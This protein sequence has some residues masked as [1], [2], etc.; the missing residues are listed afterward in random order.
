MTADERAWL[1]RVRVARRRLRA[2]CGRAMRRLTAAARADLERSLYGRLTALAARVPA[3]DGGLDA[4]LAEHPVLA[5]LV[6]SAVMQWVEAT[7]EL[8]TRWDADR[9]LV[10]ALHEGRALGRVCGVRCDLSDPHG[11]GR[12]VAVVRT[13]R[14]ATVVY[15]PRPLRVD[16]AFEG[17]VR[18]LADAAPTLPPLR[19]VHTIDRGAY[20]WAEYVQ[21]APCADDAARERYHERVGALLCLA[22]LLRGADLHGENVIAAGEQPLLVDLEALP[23][24]V[25]PAFRV[26]RGE[27]DASSVLHTGLLPAVYVGGDG[28]GFVA[29]GIA[30]TAEPVMRQAVARGFDRTYRA[31]QA[32]RAVFLARAGPL[33][34]FRGA[35]TRLVLR[36]TSTYA[37]LLRR[38]TAA[39]CLR[40]AE[41]RAAEL[42]VLRRGARGG[43]GLPEAVVGAERAALERGDVPLFRLAADGVALYA[44]GARVH[45]RFASLSGLSAVRRR[46]RAMSDGARIAQ[47]HYVRVALAADAQR[48]ATRDG[49]TPRSH[50]EALL[51]GAREVAAL[52]GT[53]AV[54]RR[55]GAVW[56]G[57]RATAGGVRLVRLG[58]GLSDGQAG[59]ALFLAALAARRPDD[60]DGARL[61]RAAFAPVAAAVRSGRARHSRG[62]A[63]ALAL[64]AAALGDTVLCDAAVHAVTDDA[65]PAVGRERCLDLVRRVWDALAVHD[66]SGRDDVLAAA[67]D[68]GDRLAARRARWGDDVV[69]AGAA[70]AA[71]ATRTGISRLAAA[72]DD[73]LSLALERPDDA[74]LVELVL[75]L[76]DAGASWRAELARAAGRL[77]ERESSAPAAL[78]WQAHG[79]IDALLSASAT[80]GC[81]TLRDAAVARAVAALAHARRRG[82]HAAHPMEEPCLPGMARG[83][84]GAGYALLRAARPERVPAVWRLVAG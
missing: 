73:A 72:A 38:A 34:A 15:K 8:V 4:V 19:A 5:R 6:A 64:G 50:E 81:L 46:V 29:G 40:D 10:A 45:A 82:S 58:A 44:D 68:A 48:G 79:A 75:A 65:R 57:H 3:S 21:A 25:M 9:K 51:G 28:R 55:G 76:A 71:L 41:S 17:L 39:R 61:A 35:P 16:A 7:A 80:L 37:L 67:V 13:T 52:L 26:R 2:R 32:R 74:A 20:G 54:V 62:A 24:P 27:P 30:S 53:L 33:A 69:R 1:T 12:A 22:Y 60:E 18:W 42:A 31:V 56:W 14:G 43:A 11:G 63:C 47:H 23:S 66:A 70:L 78:C 36:A 59:V 84:A 83:L 77:V 49:T